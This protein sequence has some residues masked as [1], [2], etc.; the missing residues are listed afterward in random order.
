MLLPVAPSDSPPPRPETHVAAPADA[1]PAPAG[2]ERRRSPRGAYT[3]RVLAS[4]GGAGRML[5][6]RDLSTGGMRVERSAELALGD[7]LKLA[8]YGQPGGAAVLV[9]AR[10]ARDAGPRGWGLEF[11]GVSPAIAAH[12][13]ELVR[14]LPRLDEPRDDAG[15]PALVVSRIVEDD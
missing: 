13:D 12:L 4:G 11:L 14:S 2:R 15:G 9:R 8:L 5:A 6:G 3:R 7:E 10:V 1:A